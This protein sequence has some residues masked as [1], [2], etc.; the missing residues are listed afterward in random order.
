MFTEKTY[1]HLVRGRIVLNFGPCG[2]YQALELDGWK[3]P[4]NIDLSWD[5]EPN[6][7]HRFNGYIEML[8]TILNKP[9]EQLH[10]WFMINQDVVEHNYNML[11]NKP[12]N[13][14]L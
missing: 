14:I 12:Y 5:S 6:T 11:E 7:E 1:E 8:Q 9:I 3:L 2:F 10:E 4:K 13:Y